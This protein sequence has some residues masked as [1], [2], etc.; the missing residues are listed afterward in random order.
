MRFAFMRENAVEFDTGTNRVQV[1][2][3]KDSFDF[4]KVSFLYFAARMRQR[5]REVAVV[6]QN[7]QTFRIVIEP[8]YGENAPDS[9]RQ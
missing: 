1:F 9:L 4:C 8:S 3:R 7:Q 6:C 5:V 2:F